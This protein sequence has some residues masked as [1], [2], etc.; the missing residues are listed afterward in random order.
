MRCYVNF[1]E[2]RIMPLWT[3]FDKFD[4]NTPKKI[5]YEEIPMLFRPG[6]LTFVPSSQ[7]ASKVYYQ[8]AIQNNF[9]M[10]VCCPLDI[11]YRYN[12]DKWETPSER[13]FWTLYCLDHDGETFRTLWETVKFD[14]F[15]GE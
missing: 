13:T 4:E 14:S 2:Q 1:V 11:Y 15:P 9:R 10:Y 8:S 3:Q 12:S 7:N 6:K 5:C